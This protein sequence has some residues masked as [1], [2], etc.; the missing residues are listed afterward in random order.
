MLALSRTEGQEIVIDAGGQRITVRVIRG[1]HNVRLGFDAPDD[2]RI[3]RA[4]LLQP[5]S[6]EEEK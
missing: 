2:V 5:D 6:H 3:L 1:G 4:E